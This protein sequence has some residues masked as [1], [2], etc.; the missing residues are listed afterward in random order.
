MFGLCVFF[1]CSRNRSEAGWKR[2]PCRVAVL[3]VEAFQDGLEVVF[4]RDIELP[5]WS[6]SVDVETKEVSGRSRVRAFE[7]CIELAF[8][9]VQSRPI[10]AGDELVID[11][12]REHEELV[13]PAM[14]V[15]AG[16]CFGWSEALGLEPFVECLVEAA[17]GLLQAVERLAE[18]EDLVGGN[19]ASLWWR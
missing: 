14:R 10:V 1:V 13:S 8:E 16:V 15:E 12:N 3:Q 7:L 18:V 19:V 11:M 5:C 17:W 9:V 2:S 6:V 4:L